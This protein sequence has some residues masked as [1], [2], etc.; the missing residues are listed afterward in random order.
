GRRPGLL[1]EGLRVPRERG[2]PARLPVVALLGGPQRLRRRD[3]Q[4]P[5]RPGRRGTGAGGRRGGTRTRCSART[6]LDV[7]RAP[8]AQADLP[9]G[10]PGDV[11]PG[12]RRRDVDL[13]AGRRD[14]AVPGEVVAAPSLPTRRRRGERT[15]LAW[16]RG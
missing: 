7:A 3:P 2:L 5:G 14:R 12:D 9:A 1:R 13:A 16:I 11:L 6:S 4:V 10:V 8:P 15:G